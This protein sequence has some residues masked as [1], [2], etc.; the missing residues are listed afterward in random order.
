MNSGKFN[1]LD[2]Y[3]LSAARERAIA[4]I[5]EQ[6]RLSDPNDNSALNILRL[7]SGRLSSHANR[8]KGAHAENLE[9]GFMSASDKKTIWAKP[10]E[11]KGY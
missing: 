11:T 4:K 8:K 7:L 6:G 5:A 10:I 9:K 1:A 2:K 3:Q